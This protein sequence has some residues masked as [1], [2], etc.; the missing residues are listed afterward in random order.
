MTA[1]TPRIEFEELDLDPADIP[2]PVGHRILIA[3]LKAKEQVGKI[4][5]PEAAK[6]AERLLMYTGRVIGMGPR[7]YQHAKKF[8]NPETGECE[9]WC[10]LGDI[11]VHGQYTGQQVVVIDRQGNKVNLRIVNDDEIRMKVPAPERILTYV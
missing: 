4:L 7:C 3:P 8:E 10:E 6:E 1:E 9:P 2:V 11:V 5:L